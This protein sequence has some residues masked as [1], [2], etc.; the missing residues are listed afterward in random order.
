MLNQLDT[1]D[2]WLDHA[3]KLAQDSGAK[4][5]QQAVLMTRAELLA[6]EHRDAEAL[7]VL[8]DLNKSGARHIAAQRLA[9]KSMTR[10][11]A[12]EDALKT[13]RQLE[14]HRAVHPAVDEAH[15]RTGL[16]RDCLRPMIQQ[17]R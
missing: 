7:A 11:G 15:A 8:G 9:L 17:V 2:Q 5:L 1:R 6:D 12:W 4:P 16:C 10:A 13:A 3:G 14:E